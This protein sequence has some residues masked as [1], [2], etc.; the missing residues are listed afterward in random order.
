MLAHCTSDAML[1][2]ALDLHVDSATFSQ[3]WATTS[4]TNLAAYATF[5]RVAGITSG[6]SAFHILP[7]GLAGGS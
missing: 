5:R 7:I 1:D 6:L 3:W 2:A 4:E